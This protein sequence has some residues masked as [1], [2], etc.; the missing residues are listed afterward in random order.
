MTWEVYKKEMKDS[1]R[2]QKTLFLSVFI[3]MLFSIGLIFFM[4]K[5]FF[6]DTEEILPVAV[7]ANID[8]A[9]QEWVS[10]TEGIKVIVTEDPVQQV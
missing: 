1:I 5:I 7:D 10:D 2:D 9:V 8:E 3:P 4:E 6:G